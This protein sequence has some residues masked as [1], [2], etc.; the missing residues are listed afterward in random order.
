VRR[1][2]ITFKTPS[3]SKRS[4]RIGIAAEISLLFDFLQK[5]WQTVPEL[6]FGGSPPIWF[7]AE[8]EICVN[9]ILGRE[10]LKGGKM[11]IF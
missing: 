11:C 10:I 6:L 8:V 4:L 7:P 2:T 9:G 5:F 3:K 1:Q